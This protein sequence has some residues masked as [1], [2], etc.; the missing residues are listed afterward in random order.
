[1]KKQLKINIE[2]IT[3]VDNLVLFDDDGDGWMDFDLF[4]I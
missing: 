4:L 3:F 1:M 2:S